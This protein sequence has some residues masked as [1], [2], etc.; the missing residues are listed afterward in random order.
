MADIAVVF[1]WQ[2][3]EMFEMEVAELRRWRTHAVARLPTKS[4]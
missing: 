4:D 3:S 1:H 2:P